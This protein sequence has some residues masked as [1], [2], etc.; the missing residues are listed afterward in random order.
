V[1]DVGIFAVR[2]ADFVWR[3][4]HIA[5]IR[6]H[7]VGL[8]E[9]DADG[10]DNVDVAVDVK[11]DDVAAFELRCCDTLAVFGVRAAGVKC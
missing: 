9:L 10:K 5:V 7:D 8:R 6:P 3:G 11:N 2:H 1:N 4:V